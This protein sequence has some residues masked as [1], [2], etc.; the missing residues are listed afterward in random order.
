MENL[1]TDPEVLWIATNVTHQDI[2]RHSVYSCWKRVFEY[3]H[4]TVNL[5]NPKEIS[6]KSKSIA[7]DVFYE[8]VKGLTDP[9][10]IFPKGSTP[11]SKESVDEALFEAQTSTSQG[12]LIVT[13]KVE[14]IQ[15][16]ITQNVKFY[17]S[18]TKNDFAKSCIDPYRFLQQG[19]IL[20][21]SPTLLSGFEWPT[22][23]YEVRGVPPRLSPNMIMHGMNPPEKFR[24]T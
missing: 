23:I 7:E 5:R 15:N 3:V 19:G 8:H 10:K 14:D 4:L 22:I 13:D 9:P 20:I 2:K 11:I 17:H 12:I 18:D 21:T 1:S 24:G 6:K 16:T